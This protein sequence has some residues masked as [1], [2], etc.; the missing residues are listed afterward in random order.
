MKKYLVIGNAESVH[1]VKWIK[2]L[3]KYFEVFVLS[4]KG[5]RSEIIDLLPE[6]NIF[7]LDLKI[8]EKG[9]NY[10]LLFKLFTI[11]KIIRGIN[12]DYVN[13]HYITSHGFVAALIKKW[14]NSHYYLI[15]SA[16]GSDILVT[17][18]KNKLYYLITRFS[19]NQSNLITSDSEYMTGI[20]RKLSDRDIMTFI[21]GLDSLPEVDVSM[22]NPN[23]F[24]SNRI[25]TGNYKIEDV[26]LLFRQI[27]KLNPSA[28]LI[29]SNDGYQRKSLENLTM[30]LGLQNK[31]EFIGFVSAEA[32]MSIYQRAQYYISLPVSDSTSVSL[33]EAM[34]YGCIPVLSDIP[35]NREWITDGL[36]G[37]I[38]HGLDKD[39]ESIFKALNKREAILSINREIVKS[40]AI[41]PD[42]VKSFIN[43]IYKP[44]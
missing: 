30:E 8:S 36:N 3:L 9:G 38:C 4:S 29:V 28:S 15:Q 39:A 24:Y 20:I 26:I 32:Q 10:K 34:A 7:T 6:Q 19:L 13:A 42:S 16:W 17:S 21:F 12:P 37:I 14:M 11:K 1:L 27:S 41:F 40:K 5:V 43:R 18:F 35:A 22:K 23:L 25:L 44:V 31:V 2:E 33:I